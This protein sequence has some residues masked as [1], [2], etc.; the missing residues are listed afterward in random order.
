MN[1]NLTSADKANRY[2]HARWQ[3]KRRILRF[4]I[5]HIGIRFL[6]RLDEVRGVENVPAHG[7]AILF[8]NHIALVDPVVIIHCLPRQIVPL[9]KIEVYDYP[10]IGIFPR[11]WG[12]IPVKREEFDRRAIRRALDV[13]HAGEILLLAPEGTR[14]PQMQAAKEGLAYLAS[15]AN[16]PLVPVGI[17]GTP[18]YPSLRGSPSWRSV[19]VTVR[20]GRPF[21]FRPT[22]HG[23]SH[24][25]QMTNEAMYT[26]AA[27][28]PEHRRGVY[29]D[30]AQATDETIEWLPLP[31]AD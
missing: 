10:V 20:F 27:L 17:D 26:L 24:L 25:H 29:G 28:L 30:L 11:L 13:L 3:T 12:V 4:L 23:H 16:V 6:L 19:G 14:S 5:R 2:D 18:H 22:A 7:P 15:R 21:R 8:F 31:P 1:H 9:A